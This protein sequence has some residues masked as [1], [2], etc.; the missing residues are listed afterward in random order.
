MESA[1]TSSEKC[2]RI[3]TKILE[4]VEKKKRVEQTMKL[5]QYVKTLKEL[6]LHI[7]AGQILSDTPKDE[8]LVPPEL[9][10]AAHVIPMEEMAKLDKFRILKEL[11]EEPGSLIPDVEELKER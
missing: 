5:L 2:G 11:E 7:S 1:Q 8:H 6:E 3:C 4:D 10:T 9:R